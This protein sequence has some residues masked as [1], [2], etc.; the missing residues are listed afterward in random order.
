M[1]K[2]IINLKIFML[3]YDLQLQFRKY[4]FFKL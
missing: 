4:N 3:I 2:A 1:A